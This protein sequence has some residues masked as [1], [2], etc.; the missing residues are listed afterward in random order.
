MF[1][2]ARCQK[3]PV[4]NHAIFMKDNEMK[5]KINSNRSRKAGRTTALGLPQQ[6]QETKSYGP[7]SG[8]ATKTLTFNLTEAVTESVPSALYE[9]VKLR[10]E[11]NVRCLASR[12]YFDP[13]DLVGADCWDEFDAEDKRMAAICIGHLYLTGALTI[14]ASGFG[15]TPPTTYYLNS[16]DGPGAH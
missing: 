9:H 6:R 16:C 8:K 10:V 2:T 11:Q 4:V 1:H 3:Q 5:T 7:F 15:L 14:C 12:D 13:K